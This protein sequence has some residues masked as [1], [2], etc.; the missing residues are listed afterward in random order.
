MVRHRQV[1]RA[2]F[3]LLLMSGA[4]LAAAANKGLP[5]Y[6]VAVYSDLCVEGDSGEIGGQRISLHRFAEGD[7]VIYEF[8]AGGLSMP[9]VASDVSI[10]DATGVL[11]FTVAVSD[12][13]ERT[14]IGRFA[15]DGRVLTLTGGYC[16][17]AALPMR[18]NRVG[19]FSRPLAACRACPAPVSVPQAAPPA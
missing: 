14:I 15:K 18:L 17:D 6:G 4:A 8:T 9:L 10:D 1:R 5:R 12:S 19:D 7:S 11:T 16:G 2:A 3:A 13:E